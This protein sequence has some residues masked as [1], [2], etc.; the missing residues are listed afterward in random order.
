M[1]DY[2]QELR[3]GLFPNPDATRVPE[4]LALVQLAEVEGLDLVSIQDHPYQARHLD[5]WTLLSLLGGRTSEI[6]LAPNVASLP[7]RPPVVLAKSAATLD[8]LTGGRVEIGLGAG[9]FWDAIVAAGGP[10]R[11]PRDAVDALDEAVRLMKEFWAGGSLHFAG[12]HYQAT[13]L[14]AGPRPAHDIPIWIGAYKPRMLR[15]T[16]RLADGWV[17]SMGYVEPDSLPAMNAAI[18]E[19]AEKAG[20]A[21]ASIRRIYNINGRFG[22]G[23]GL[24]QGDPRAWAEQLAALTLE[25]GMSTYILGT[26]NP[27]DVRRFATEVAPA[28]RELV[29][30]ERAQPSGSSELTH[31]SSTVPADS[32]PLAVSA[33]QDDGTRLTGQLAWDEASRPTHAEPGGASYPSSLQGQ[34]QHLVDIHDGLRA[35][36]EQ[37]RKVLKQ[38]REGHLTVGAARSVINTM[39]MRQNNW[40]LGAYCESYCRVVTGHHTLE[41]R[42]IFPH[43]RRAEPD[44]V[45]VLERLQTE[46]EVIHEVLEEFDK[47]L[48]LLVTSDG[49]GHGG[50]DALDQVQQRLDLLTDTLLSHLAYE[51][52]ELI[53]PLSRHGL[54]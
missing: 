53:G 38:V 15:L 41:D 40:T 37:V 33:T 28:V 20:R 44:L 16:G 18:D 1:T 39:T 47:A 14:H 48:V 25:H 10:R 22:S 29:D 12:K 35:E 24:L 19:A 17:P 42:S 36:L 8:L 23:G 50:Q 51:E 27:D 11:A 6:T 46:H 52:R 2:G 21:P 26:D 30:A 4:L 49:V 54:Q 5:T 7:L 3:F 9:A 32:A 13:G 43:L 31:E 45:P 34:A